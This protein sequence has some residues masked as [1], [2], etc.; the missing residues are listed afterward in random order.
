[1]NAKEIFTQHANG[2]II[3]AHCMQAFQKNTQN[4]NMPH[5]CGGWTKSVAYILGHWQCCL[6]IY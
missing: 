3:E 1:V 4:E 5:G 2:S 6:V